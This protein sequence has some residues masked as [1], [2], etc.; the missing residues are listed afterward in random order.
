MAFTKPVEPLEVAL[1][2]PE[3]K[4]GDLDLNEGDTFYLCKNVRGKFERVDKVVA[5]GNTVRVNKNCYGTLYLITNHLGDFLDV[6][7]DMDIIGLSKED[8][9]DKI[10]YFQNKTKESNEKLKGFKSTLRDV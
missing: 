10:R 3:R 6:A 5:Q 1:S 7:G 9:K 2:P 8:V 4:G